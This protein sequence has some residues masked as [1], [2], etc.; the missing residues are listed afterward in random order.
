MLIQEQCDSNTHLSR[1]FSKRQQL[2]NTEI[3]GRVKLK[4]HKKKTTQQ[5]F[6]PAQTQPTHEW[7]SSAIGAGQIRSKRSTQQSLDGT[8]TESACRNRTAG[9]GRAAV[10]SSSAAVAPLA[11]SGRAAFPTNSPSCCTV[12]TTQRME[13]WQYVTD[14]APSLRTW[15][16]YKDIR[17]CSFHRQHTHTHTHLQRHKDILISAHRHTHTRTHTCTHEHTQTLT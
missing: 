2:T 6:T 5:L 14:G 8:P 1:W 3:T 4:T 7:S 16:T 9:E 13:W 10:L 12:S 15:I 17:I 11:G